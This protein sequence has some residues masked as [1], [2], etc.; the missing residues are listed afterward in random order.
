MTVRRCRN[1]PS[2]PPPLPIRHTPSLQEVNSATHQQQHA[3]GS[4]FQG[5]SQSTTCLPSE[6][7]RKHSGDYVNTSIG[8]TP[9]LSNSNELTISSDDVFADSSTP[10]EQIIY[11]N[12]PKPKLLN[13]RMVDQYYVK[14][15]GLASAQEDEIWEESGLK[16][17]SASA[18]E[19]VLQWKAESPAMIHRTRSGYA[20]GVDDVDADFRQ[21]ST[22]TL[23]PDP[24]VTGSTDSLSRHSAKMNGNAT[25]IRRVMERNLLKNMGR[26]N[27]QPETASP[28]SCNYVADGTSSPQLASPTSI[29]KVSQ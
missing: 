3:N 23:V 19:D 17:Q 4:F 27:S 15:G 26:Y 12:L 13:S 24:S 11:V 5:M 14:R 18:V 1:R 2:A 8:L 16:T 7:S 28:S 21:S 20:N 10:Q 9:H 29:G 6:C 25:P 22:S